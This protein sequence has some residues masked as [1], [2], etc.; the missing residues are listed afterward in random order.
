MSAYEV[1]WLKPERILYVNYK[2]HQT[3]ETV[4]ACMDL[5]AVELDKMSRPVVVLVNW[6]EVTSVEPGTIQSTSGHRGYSHP[7]AARGVLV[8]FDEQLAFQNTLSAYATR[9]SQHTIYFKTLD[10]ALAYLKD[11][12]EGD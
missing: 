9:Q 12:L 7:M 11:L 5:Q 8:G 2:G 1:Y 3:P 4:N 10:E 6:Q